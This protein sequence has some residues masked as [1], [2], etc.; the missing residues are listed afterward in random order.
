MNLDE[1]I[2]VDTIW[3]LKDTNY[4]V[5]VVSVTNKKVSYYFLGAFNLLTVSKRDFYIDFTRDK[6]NG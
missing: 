3:T 2:E 1:L 6:L 5:K 4:K